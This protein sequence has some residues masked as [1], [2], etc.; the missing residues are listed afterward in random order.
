MTIVLELDTEFFLSK[1]G[2]SNNPFNLKAFD[3]KFF[4]N[5]V[6]FTLLK[7]KYKKGK[8]LE[9]KMNNTITTRN[10][11]GNGTG[12]ITKNETVLNSLTKPSPI[13]GVGN[14]GV[15]H[16]R[17]K[18]L[19]EEGRVFAIAGKIKKREDEHLQVLT[20]KARNAAKEIC[21]SVD[22]TQADK[23]TQ[24]MLKEFKADREL[25]K[26]QVKRAEAN[27]LD[28][29]IKQ[30]DVPQPKETRPDEPMLLVLGSTILI[31]MPVVYTV[32][33]L[34]KSGDPVI[35]FII[36]A[37]ISTGIGFAIAKLLFYV[38]ATKSAE[39]T[40]PTLI[41]WLAAVGLAIGLGVIR[42]AL[43]SSY[44]MAIGFS[45]FEFFLVLVIEIAARRHRKAVH[46]WDE[47][48]E[49]YEKARSL[50][51]FYQ[52]RVDD[53]SGRKERLDE[54]IEAIRREL[55]IVDIIINRPKELEDSFASSIEAGYEQGI[56]EVNANY[57]D[58][59]I[60]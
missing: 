36:A 21:R 28:S 42:I 35:N 15:T 14:E 27:L 20:A 17:H 39:D 51:G 8:S 54:N 3:Q 25:V 55:K 33:E 38:P 7:T 43:S 31:A 41:A 22:E 50:T 29:Q 53:L 49:N 23:E 46:A 12:F 47:K 9:K 11:N 52:N 18:E 44:E 13:P 40:N 10:G 48:N 59:V 24:E 26:E 32:V 34:W 30:T 19:F 4:I 45:V 58:S 16:P 2:E 1:K 6:H 5:R 56:A 60:R 57:D 37:M